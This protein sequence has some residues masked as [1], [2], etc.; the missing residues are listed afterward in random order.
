[1]HST[2]KSFA[3]IAPSALAHMGDSVGTEACLMPL[4]VTVTADAN[5]RNAVL[6][7]L[8]VRAKEDVHSM[9]VINVSS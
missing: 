6:V 7:L 4:C 9:V 1:M 2:C 5:E 3:G 8:K